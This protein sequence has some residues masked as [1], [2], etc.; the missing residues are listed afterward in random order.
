MEKETM[1][2]GGGNPDDVFDVR[3]V[4]RLVELMQEFDLAEVDLRQAEQRIRLRKDL[5]PVIVQG[6]SPVLRSR[7][8]G[9][10]GARPRAAPPRPRRLRPPRPCRLRPPPPRRRKPPIPTT[11]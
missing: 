1:G 2:S 10:V 6:G 11:S 9:G 8:R 7:R 5:E 4:R 3:R